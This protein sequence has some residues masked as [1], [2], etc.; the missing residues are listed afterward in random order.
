MQYFYNHILTKEIYANQG[1]GYDEEN[2]DHHNASEDLTAL[3][4][5]FFLCFLFQLML[6]QLERDCRGYFRFVIVN[7]IYE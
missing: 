3:Q 1:T 5:F 7:Q 2:E 4:T 6:V